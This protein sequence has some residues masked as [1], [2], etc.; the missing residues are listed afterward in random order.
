MAAARRHGRSEVAGEGHSYLQDVLVLLLAA[1]VVV[2]LFQR[3]RVSPV[4]AYLV[5]GIALGPFALGL[6]DEVEGA[7]RLAELGVIFLLFTVGLELPFARVRAIWRYIFGLGLAQVA[8]TSLAIG[9]LAHALGAAPAAALVIGAA[10]AFSSTATVLQL[11]RER[12][13][14]ATRFGRLSLAVLLFQ[15]LAVVPLLA[16]LP[17]LH[18]DPASLASALALAFVKAAAT[19]AVILLLGRIVLSPLFRLVAA[20]RNAELFAAATLLVALGTSWATEQVGMSAA[21][22][23]FLAGMLLAGTEFRHQVEADIQPFRG[24]FLGLFFISVGMTTDLGLVASHLP[25]LAAASAALLAGKAAV[26]LLLGLAARLGLALSARIALTL[27]QG[28]EFAFVVFTLAGRSGLIPA[29]T[30]GI[31]VAAVA[32]TLFATPFLAV[33]GRRIAAALERGPVPETARLGSE[34]GEL[35]N[36]LILAG[37]GRV[38]RIVG[39]LLAAHELPFVAIDLDPGRVAEL[40]R[41]GAPVFFGDA[42]RAEVLHAAGIERAVCVV[43]TLDEPAATE[44]IVEALHRQH[45]DVPILARAR[46]RDHLQRLQRAGA[47]TIVL[48]AVEPGLQMGAAALRRAGMAGDEA[49]SVINEARKEYSSNP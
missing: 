36:H 33:L 9:L 16:L 25:A 12:G 2:P 17:I 22:G 15:D 18:G 40:R 7:Q 28:G 29:E 4:L 30:A 41:R 19:L 11:L 48:E 39:R 45:P 20:T 32:L 35:A 13:E 10:L 21:L 3:L 6:V 47:G 27:A 1:I 42:S 5:A 31:L 23:A 46:D 44:K 24:L 49:E 14:L 34:A 38:G 8:L 26:L 37:Y 43:V